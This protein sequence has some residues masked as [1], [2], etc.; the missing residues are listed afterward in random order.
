MQDEITHRLSKA[1]DGAA[2]AGWLESCIIQ[3][4]AQLE[5]GH[6][7]PCE[8][9]GESAEEENENLKN[10]GERER[11]KREKN[12]HFPIA[13]RRESAIRIHIYFLP[14]CHT[15]AAGRP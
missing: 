12:E 1:N 4:I 6:E 14:S 11:E 10:L 7:V 15:A 9:A 8:T 2:A 5:T 13:A 3:I